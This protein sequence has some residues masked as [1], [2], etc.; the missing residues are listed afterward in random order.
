MQTS[1]NAAIDLILSHEGGFV[2]DPRDPGGATNLG[3]TLA[4]YRR[5]AT[6]RRT[7]M[8][9]LQTLIQESS[10][11]RGIVLLLTAAGLALSLDQQAAIL[12]AGIAGLIGAF[13]ADA[14]HRG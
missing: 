12:T 10:T 5:A 9:K 7:P 6:R 2:D 13:F 4:T 14:R 8:I 1:L 11:W 3:I